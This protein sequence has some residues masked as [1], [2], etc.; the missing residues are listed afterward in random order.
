MSGFPI[1]QS[2]QAARLQAVRARLALLIQLHLTR[3]RRLT[4]V[5]DCLA[6]PVFCAT[7]APDDLA[8]LRSHQTALEKIIVLLEHQ[9]V[10]TQVLIDTLE[11]AQPS[12]SIPVRG[13]RRSLAWRWSR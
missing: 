6:D 11:R 8:M 7:V 13:R 9:H 12:N 10:G 4:Q 2:Q 3:T 1:D 5:T